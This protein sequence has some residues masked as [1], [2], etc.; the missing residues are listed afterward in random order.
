[1]LSSTAQ[2]GKEVGLEETGPGG[3]EKGTEARWES[4]A[5]DNCLSKSDCRDSQCCH[6]FS[7]IWER[8]NIQLVTLNGEL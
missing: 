5:T 8:Q 1:M 4:M 2:S 6:E 7:K 3:A